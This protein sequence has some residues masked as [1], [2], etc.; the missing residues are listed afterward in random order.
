MHEQGDPA[1]DRDHAVSRL[2]AACAL[3]RE[4]AIGEAVSILGLLGDPDV[5]ELLGTAERSLRYAA[6]LE[7]RVARGD[8]AGA[9]ALG[10]GLADFLAAPGLTAAIAHHASGEL[11]SALGDPDLA[12]K[13]FLAVGEET[14]D[15][16]VSPELLP[17][18][19]G[20]ALA[21][22]RLGR[23][24]EAA[25]FAELHHAEAL[26]T[27]S[28]YAIAVALRTL[29]ATVTGG[30]RV[31]LLRQARAT[32]DGVPADRLLAQIDTDLAG[33]LLLSRDV[34]TSE[35][36]AM[37]RAAESFAGRQ[38]LWPLQKR[39]RRL[40]DHLGEAPQQI[41]SE[42]VASLTAAERRVAALA[43]EG[44]TNRQIAEQLLVSI[45]AIEWHLSNVYRKLEIRS[46]KALAPSIGA[47][48]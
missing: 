2:D 23:G 9:M 41:D 10:H 46:R 42:A 39:V 47:T 37:L 1:A 27:G 36:L 31:A 35:A 44:L 7:C 19:A 25:E 16:P 48:A 40:L 15:D 4:G 26:A 33:A 14:A 3:V 22:L 24:Q 6:L 12:L 20:A 30:E 45:K 17:W 28:A 38:E 29:A 21:L 18:R 32:L 11:A 34:E 8:L 13:H 5:A 43:A